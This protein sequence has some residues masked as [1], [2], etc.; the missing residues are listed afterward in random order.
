MAVRRIFRPPHGYIRLLQLCALRMS[1]YSVVL[2]DIVSR[3]FDP[4]LTSE[5]VVANVV[6][7]IRDG[8]LIVFHDSVKAF[9]RLRDAL[10]EILSRLCVTGTR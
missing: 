3:D 7:N 8:S 9:P 6:E 4:A 5:E 2:F 10:P 1:G